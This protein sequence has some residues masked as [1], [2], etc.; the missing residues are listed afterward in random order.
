M[1]HL[2]IE[3]NNIPENVSAHLLKAIYDYAFSGDLDN[4]SNFSGSLTALHGY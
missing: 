2:R 4:S 1:T 3:Q